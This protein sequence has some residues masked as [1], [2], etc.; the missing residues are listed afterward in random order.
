MAQ[1]NIRT[2]SSRDFHWNGR[3]GTVDASDLGLDIFGTG[4]F[5]RMYN[6]SAD[7]GFAVRSTKTG[8][9]M[10]F[11]FYDYLRNVDGDSL[12]WKFQSITDD[13]C[14]IHVYND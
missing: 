6:D 7:T 1:L 10:R 9:V 11:A 8:R 3:H 5:N 2:F 12:G 14:T 4:L 13:K